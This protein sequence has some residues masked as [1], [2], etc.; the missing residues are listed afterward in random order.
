MQKLNY[1]EIFAE[2]PTIDELSL[3]ER[4]PLYCIVEDVRSLNNVG[5]IF[6]TSDAVRLQKLY[7]TGYTG[8]PPR[9][10][11]EKT[12]LGATETVPWI[13]SQSTIDV[14][15]ELKQK[16][17]TIVALEHTTKSRPYFEFKYNYPLCLLLGNEV[18]GLNEK[19]VSMA[20]HSIEIPM[21]GLKQSLNVSVAYGVVI[22]HILDQYLKSK[23]NTKK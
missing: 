21:F 6:R 5:S 10:E 20:E 17:V 12:A 7:L 13:H 8:C 23:K 4:F 14:I 15:Q 16:N 19:T 3:L 2:M 11:I 18:D 22:F 1:E 9:R